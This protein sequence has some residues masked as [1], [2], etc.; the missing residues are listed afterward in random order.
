MFSQNLTIISI[1]FSGQKQ[2]ESFVLFR[3]VLS[4]LSSYSPAEVVGVKSEDLNRQ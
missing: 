1:G 2:W 4:L 3:V